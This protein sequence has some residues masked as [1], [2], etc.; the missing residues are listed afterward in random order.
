MSK[1]CGLAGLVAGRSCR[2][3]AG[4]LP[5]RCLAQP[6]ARSAGRQRVRRQEATRRQDRR[7]SA[8]TTQRRDLAC[9]KEPHP[10]R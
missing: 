10:A 3:G 7:G 2:G 8:T 4:E 6:P 5:T 1:L 9:S